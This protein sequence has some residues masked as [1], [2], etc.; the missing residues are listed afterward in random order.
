M[1]KDEV[2]AAPAN[3]SS[4]QKERTILSQ[5]N[6]PDST[7]LSKSELAIRNKAPNK[8]AVKS[9]R[10]L[11]VSGHPFYPSNFRVLTKPFLSS[12]TLLREQVDDLE[13]MLDDTYKELAESR[14]GQASLRQTGKNFNKNFTLKESS[15]EEEERCMYLV[16]HD[17]LEA[18]LKDGVDDKK[19]KQPLGV[20]L[21]PRGHETSSKINDDILRRAIGL[22]M[23]TPRKN[24]TYNGVRLRSSTIV[25]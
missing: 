11:E 25:G 5:V 23:A 16:T 7:F 24:I 20:F 8:Q 9:D 12:R 13:L 22:N 18:L 17:E 14:P 15:H 10:V 21:I 4:F 19:L 6:G 1:A 2:P 3:K